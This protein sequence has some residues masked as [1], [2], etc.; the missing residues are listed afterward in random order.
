M[1]EAVQW[2]EEWVDGELATE[3]ILDPSPMWSTEEEN[4][5]EKDDREEEWWWPDSSFRKPP[6]IVPPNQLKTS[7][8]ILAVW[9][10]EMT[11]AEDSG[12]PPVGD[13]PDLGLDL[14]NDWSA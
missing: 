6:F 9:V 8:E 2:L 7:E 12:N 14:V 13:I 4:L 3:N 5:E 10:L 11:E 1:G